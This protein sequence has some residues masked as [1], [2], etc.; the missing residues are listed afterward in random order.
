MSLVSMVDTNL[1]RHQAKDPA[2]ISPAAPVGVSTNLIN[3]VTRWIPTETITVYVILLA[4]VAPVAAHSASFTS[5]WVLF[6]VITSANPVVVVLLAMAR[7][8]VGQVFKLPVFEMII[9]PIAFAAWAF[10]LPDTPLRSIS[11]YGIRWN[12]A[13][14]T[15]TTVAIT[16]VANALHKSPDFDQVVTKQQGADPRSPESMGETAGRE[17]SAALAMR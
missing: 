3:Q 2:E 13:I 5:R 11:G 17:E 4:L 15:I 8:K 16:L 1:A 7:T 10:A 6:W 12:T 9:A 14:L